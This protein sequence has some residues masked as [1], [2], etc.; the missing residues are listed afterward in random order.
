MYIVFL[1]I[2]KVMSEARVKL[3]EFGYGPGDNFPVNETIK[4]SK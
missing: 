4:E 1:F 2:P 3:M